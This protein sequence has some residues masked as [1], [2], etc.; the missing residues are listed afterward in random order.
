MIYVPK[1]M[2][3]DGFLQTAIPPDWALMTPERA[4]GDIRAALDGARANLAQI[5]ALGGGALA[6][7]NTVR[8]LDR[9]CVG[10]NR[11][12]GYLN[13]LEN[14]MTSEPLR[15]AL[16]ALLPEVSG[17]FSSI[18]LDGELYAKIEAFANSPAAA[19]M[20]AEEK[21]LL[22]ETLRDFREEGA[23]LPEEKKKRL[24]EINAE[25][26]LK[27]Q[28]FSE[29]ELDSTKEFTLRITDPQDLAGLPPTAV[30]IAKKAAADRGLE[31]WVFTLD[32]PSYAPF[33]AYAENDELRR[34]LWLAATQIAVGGKY[35]N[36]QIMRQMLA[37]RA[38]KARLLGFKNFADYALSRRMARSGGRALE[39]VKSLREKFAA[40]FDTEW[41]RLADFAKTLGCA[42]IKPW[43]S[44]YF[45]EKL[46]RQK[47]DFDPE[48]LRDYFPFGAV[49]G[50][51]FKIAETVFGFDIKRESSNCGAWHPTVELYSVFKGGRLIGKFYT[52]FIPRRQKRS[53]AWMDLLSPALGGA[54]ALGVIAGNLTEPAE[55]KPAL[56]SYDDVST[57]FHEFGHLA[58]FMLMDA[59]E[60]S[61]R[62]VAWDFV[63]LPSQIM[64]NWCADKQCLDMFAAH[65]R[66]GEKIPDA[67]FEKFKRSEKFS[68]A[69]ACMRQLAFAKIDLLLHIYTGEYLAAPDLEEK[70]RADIAD[71]S[72]DFGMPV[73][74]ILPRF[75]HIFGG[76][77]AAAYYSYKWAEV[78]DA[79]A[80][81]RFKKE[82]LLNKKTGAEFVE[83]VLRPGRRVPPEK[84]FED[85]MGRPPDQ[86]ALVVRSLEPDLIDGGSK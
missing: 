27:G 2:K 70:A 24:L 67:L 77:Y 36:R 23:N 55:G 22:D 31:G 14:V 1:D 56:L 81:T 83:K 65:W 66:T 58:H 53:G 72:R 8:A 78:L 64:E 76:G 5:K 49:I 51:L 47:Y 33:M 26:S 16:N 18:L 85:F 30:E 86:N 10:L 17:F 48:L 9:A 4:A 43:Q 7:D 13:H 11:A 28:K 60:L 12:W 84:A 38:E 37:L 69:M 19:N 44:A 46:R 52:D 59:R 63:E 42:E 40:A 41:A 15:K 61:L 50:G 57:L 68:G 20:D 3:N 34:R 75:T 45:S 79:D 32:R 71:C 39:F 80:F 82:G 73:P 21:I 35:D 6:F 25:L 29:N 74:T 54:P 62:D